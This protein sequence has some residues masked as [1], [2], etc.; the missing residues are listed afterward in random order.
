MRASHDAP[1]HG[2]TAVL[3]VD[4]YPLNL[5]ALAAVLEPLGVTVET[6]ADGREA[7]QKAEE[8]TFAA[9]LLDVMMPEMDG[10]ETLHRLRKLEIAKATPVTLLTAHELGPDGLAQLDGMGT[11]DYILKPIAPVILRSKVAA[12]VELYEQRAALAAK[13]RHIA[14]LAHDLQTPL[15][16]IQLAASYLIDAGAEDRSRTFAERIVRSA[17][18]LSG[19]VRNL[20]DFA[21]A[22]TGSI[23]VVRQ[24]MDLRGLC[25]DAA[26]EL[27]P[28]SAGQ[29]QFHFEGDLSGHWDRDRLFQVLSN[30]LTNA[31][32]YGEGVVRIEGRRVGHAIE[33]SIHNGGA[34]I[35]PDL[36]PIVFQA[37]ERGAQDRVGLGLGLFIVREIVKSHGGDVSV[38]SSA[39]VGTTFTIRLPVIGPEVRSR[40]ST[41]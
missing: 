38:A 34:P 1:E 5:L 40:E 36:L 13:D 19:M 3:A 18:R 7:L 35:T 24:P 11:V 4:D 8:R 23:A 20:T 14:M 27:G 12:L 10:F 41:S 32:R 17:Q 37:F 15:S 9:I 26:D 22:G 28:G 39:E 16:A 25:R 31:L 2:A 29:V 6:A 33:L 30:L 21:R